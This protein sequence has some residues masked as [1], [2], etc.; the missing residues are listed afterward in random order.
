[1]IKKFFKLHKRMKS[2]FEWHLHSLKHNGNDWVVPIPEY[3][4]IERWSWFNNGYTQNS[5]KFYNSYVN[6]RG[7]LASYK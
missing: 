6:S 3:L 1:M 5:G 7:L 2:N 4:C